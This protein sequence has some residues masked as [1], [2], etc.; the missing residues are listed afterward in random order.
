VQ[1]IQLVKQPKKKR[2][3][4]IIFAAAPKKYEQTSSCKI[5]YIGAF[6]TRQ[7]ALAKRGELWCYLYTLYNIATPNSD[8]GSG[9][10]GTKNARG[11]SVTTDVVNAVATA[12]DRKRGVG[13]KFERLRALQLIALK[14]LSAIPMLIGVIT[15]NFILVHLAPGDPVSVLV[16]ES[17]PTDAQLAALYAKLGLNQPLYVQ[18]WEYLS[19]AFK[20]DLGYSYVLQ[21]DVVSLIIARLPATLILMLTSLIIFTLLGVILA[22]AVARKP[23]STFDKIGSLLAII[24]YSTPA[25]WLAQLVL[26]AFALNLRWFPTGGMI[27]SRQV[28]MGFAYFKDLS[29]HLILPGF[30]LGMRYLAINFRYARASMRDALSQDYIMTAKAKGLSEGRILF[31]A[32][33]NGILPII[34]VFGLNVTDILAGSILTEIVFGW[35]GL[36]RLMYDAM[37]ARDYPLL[38]GMFV[39]ISIGIIVTNLIIDIVYGIFDP[40]VG[41][42]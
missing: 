19:S 13:E 1:F 28:Y 36:G 16:G 32:F 38:M 40:R 24:G 35:P 27:D 2:E 9:D 29:M 42:K 37:Y 25:F 5:S 12:S 23:R 8:L 33:R 7:L 4:S 11:R 15:V 21:T 6:R 41:Q 20:G 34:T 10:R 3:T 30:V 26:L 31:H 17:E 22:V 14:I 39:F 18:Y